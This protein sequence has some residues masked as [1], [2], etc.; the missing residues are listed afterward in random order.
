MSV[1]YDIPGP[2]ARRRNRIIA[3]ATVVGIVAVVALVLR[4]LQVGGQLTGEKWEVFV[5]PRYLEMLAVATLATLGTAALAIV[6]AL[7]VGVFFGV[8]KL[9]DHRPVRMFAWTFVE[10]FR[11]VPLLILIYFIWYFAYETRID[12]IAPLVIGLVL[13][14]GSVLAEVFRAG[15]NAV[16]KGQVE[17]AYALGLRKTAVMRIVQL[18]QA[19][20]IMT[21]ALISQCIVAL[22][23]TSLGYIMLAP[24][25]TKTG[26]DLWRTFDNRLA[27]ALVLAAIYI[28]LNLIIARIGV[29]VQ[30]RLT[31]SKTVKPVDLESVRMGAPGLGPNA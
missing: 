9:S 25:L 2:R 14:N 27:T 10:F 11:A 13:Y 8:A 17:A 31:E 23:D 15:I 1:L 19:I 12:I 22:K 20:K 21:P 18:P 26:R 16:P 5:T 30:R 4:Q 6:F 29:Y 7:V 24:G 3:I 28:I